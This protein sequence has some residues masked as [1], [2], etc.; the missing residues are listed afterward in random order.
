[1]CELA[2]ISDLHKQVLTRTNAV[3]HLRE[4]AAAAAFRTRD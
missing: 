3:R 2:G 4:A 1:M